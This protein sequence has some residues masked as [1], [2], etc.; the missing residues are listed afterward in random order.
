MEYRSYKYVLMGTYS[1]PSEMEEARIE[2]TKSLPITSN[3]I[4]SVGYMKNKIK[5]V[6]EYI[7]I[8]TITFHS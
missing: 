6:D 2:I 1:I 8:E 4:I 3:P 7:V 5:L